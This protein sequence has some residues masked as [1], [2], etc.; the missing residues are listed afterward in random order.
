Q[1]TILDTYF[2]KGLAAKYPEEKVEHLK[3]LFEHV[4]RN[5]FDQQQKKLF[6]E[7]K[8][9]VDW[10]RKDPIRY[11]GDVRNNYQ[12]FLRGMLPIDFYCFFTATYLVSGKTKVIAVVHPNGTVRKVWATSKIV[13]QLHEEKNPTIKVRVHKKDNQFVHWSTDETFFHFFELASANQQRMQQ[14]QGE[15]RNVSLQKFHDIF[16]NFPLDYIPPHP[17]AI[18]DATIHYIPPTETL[19]TGFQ[20]KDEPVIN[21]SEDL[22]GVMTSVMMSDM[23]RDKDREESSLCDLS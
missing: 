20:P 18:A 9:H 21:T 16:T 14:W 5:V 4:A 7:L 12:Y 15:S 19:K 10:L 23:I 2:W 6:I 1:K 13:R 3:R 22:S 8:F 11:L 17:E